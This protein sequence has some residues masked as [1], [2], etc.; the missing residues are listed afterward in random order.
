MKVALTI[1]DFRPWR[2]GAQQYAYGFAQALLAQGHEVHVF[3]AHFA[4]LPEGVIAHPVSIRGRPFRR[5]AFAL[6]CARMLA[7]SE[8]DFDIVHGFGNSLRMDV[9]RPGGGVHRAWQRQDLLSIE[10]PARRL[11]TRLR[12]TLSLG[13]KAL[14]LLEGRQFAADRMDPGG[15]RLED[16]A[17]HVR[18]YYTVPDERL[19]VV[20][21]GVDTTRFSPENNGRF[22]AETRKRLG[23]GDSEVALLFVSNNFRLKGLGP[24]IRAVA[25]L[26]PERN[27]VRVVVVGRD[28]PA[29]WRA[30][31]E[32]LRCGNRISFTGP[33]DAAEQAYAAG[34]V[35]VHPTFYDPCANV[36]LEAMAAGRPVITSR[37]NGAG[38]LITPGVEGSVVDPQNVQALSDA[39]RW[40]LD[41]DRRAGGRPECAP[42]RADARHAAERS[43]SRCAFTTWH[44]RAN[45]AS[46]RLEGRTRKRLCC[47]EAPADGRVMNT[48]H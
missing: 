18:A 1:D 25:A 6:R 7:K 46:R 14:L 27:A 20:Y 2:G 26:G 17:R 28:R 39:I 15:R 3:A 37:Y 23:I 43:G 16:G 35:L 48:E 45:R 22:R 38:E 12:R 8:R 9:F 44:W 30:L 33:F 31:A 5:V 4:G 10:S 42:A 21:N 32:R 13:Q 36:T 29:P 11:C 24:L 41:E 47:E 34:D 40:F 19:H